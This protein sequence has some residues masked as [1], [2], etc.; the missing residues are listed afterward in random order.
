MR[1]GTDRTPGADKNGPGDVLCQL[2]QI[3]YQRHSP[4]G[5]DF[6][7]CPSKPF[8]C[9]MRNAEC[10]VRNLAT[11]G[12]SVTAHLHILVM[13]ADDEEIERARDAADRDCR[14]CAGI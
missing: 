9:G 1:F 10:G 5:T 13:I 11:S 14:G 3:P 12:P 7:V 8:E 4:F 2:Y 6:R